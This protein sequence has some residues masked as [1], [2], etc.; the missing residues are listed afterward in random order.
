MRIMNEKTTTM[1]VE[2]MTCTSCVSRVEKALKEVPGVTS[3]EVN[4]LSHQAKVSYDPNLVTTDLLIQAVTSTGYQ[5]S[6]P[7]ESKDKVSLTIDGMHCASCVNTI[8]T[9][10]SKLEGIKDVKVILSN[11]TALLSLDSSKVNLDTVISKI[12]DLGYKA[13]LIEEDAKDL[14]YSRNKQLIDMRNRFWLSLIFSI[15]VF[16][17]AMG[18]MVPF[19]NWFPAF[20]EWQRSF[21]IFPGMRFSLFI[22]LILTTPVQ[23][24]IAYPFYRAAWKSLRHKSASMDVLVV[25]GTTAA[26]LYSLFS[27]IYSYFVPAYEGQVFFETSAILLTFIFLGKYLEE[28]TKGRTSEA[29]KKLIELRPKTAKVER[30]GKEIEIPV[31]DVVKGDI[32]LIRP[33]DR[34]PV[35]GVVIEGQ[36]YINEAMITGESISVFKEEGDMVIGGT[37]NENGFLKVEAQRIGKDTTLNQIIKMVEEAQTSKLPIQRLADT[38]SAYFVPAVIL[39]AIITFII[40]FTLFSLGV[41]STSLL[42]VGTTIFLFAFLAAI[43]VIVISCPCALGLATP[44]AIM[45]GTGLGA[46]NGI[47]IRTGEALERAKNIEVILLDKTGTI[48]KGSPEVTNIVS[49]SSEL[50]E[51]DILQLA[52]TL[53]QG[54]EHSIAQAIR[55]HAEEKNV[56]LLKLT[57]FQAIP[58]KG[59]TATIQN[60]EYKFG[61]LKLVEESG[62][63]LSSTIRNQMINFENEGKT[64]M[65]LIRNNQVIGIVAIADTIK[66]HSPDAIKQMKKMGLKVVMVS[67]DNERAARAI[68]SNWD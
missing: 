30:D 55:S 19:S 57:D 64:T 5:A 52:A 12:E 8:E 37:I 65:L 26:Y 46:Q 13:S 43:A 9:N 3:A 63:E 61:N 15:P 16:V 11:N 33:G 39:I 58:G 53:E 50:S 36:S 48:T 21:Y 25:L 45:V 10:L 56:E 60:N 38:I 14:S 32:C 23:F 42:P 34:I 22:Q 47:L 35:D 51:T 6:V 24:V 54:S 4:L 67:G 59:V 27:I 29:I 20:A 7:S 31:D 2:G 40:W 44:T 28:V 17:F 41:V 66:D 1:V 68:A 62:V 49:L 18:H